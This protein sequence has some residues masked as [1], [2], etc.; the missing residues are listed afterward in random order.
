MKN[1]YN[2]TFLKLWKKYIT[3]CPS[4]LKI[5]DLLSKNSVIP[6]DHIAFRTFNDPRVDKRVLASHFENLG[7]TIEG[8]YYFE[9]KKLN[10]I[11]MEHS[12]PEAPK[13]FI[14]ELIISEFSSGLQDLVK[15]LIEE[16]PITMY[17]NPQLIFQGRLWETPTYSVYE[18]LR[19][20]SEYAAWMYIYGFCANHFT[21]LVNHLDGFDGLNE[22]NEYLVQ[23]DFKMNFSGGI[24]K[25]GPNVWLEQSSIMAD[26][27]DVRFKENIYTVPGCYYEFAYRYEK[28]GALFNGFVTQSAN[29]IFESTDKK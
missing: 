19:E 17:G 24:I 4:A 8:D 11:H 22:L 6:N 5:H 13:V 9:E 7:Y 25:G 3:L 18:K 26:S 10:A 15:K 2:E 27:I 12:D 23:N 14:S 28:D 16:I 1:N 29:K 21:I 20:E